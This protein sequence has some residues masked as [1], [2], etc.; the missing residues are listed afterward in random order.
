MDNAQNED[1]SH[2]TEEEQVE[3]C[4][5][6]FR[7][8]WEGEFADKEKFMYLNQKRGIDLTVVWQAYSLEFRGK[9]GFDSI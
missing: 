9:S 3:I 6:T 4:R 7:E 8:D 1:A 2:L 5:K